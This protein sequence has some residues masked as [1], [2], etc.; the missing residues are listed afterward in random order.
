MALQVWRLLVLIV[1]IA[2]MTGLLVRSSQAGR[3]RIRAGL[4]WGAAFALAM[5]LV[6][7]PGLTFLSL[8]RDFGWP[9]WLE[10]WHQ[11]DPG[12][13]ATALVLMGIGGA[14]AWAARPALAD[15]DRRLA[16]ETA[17]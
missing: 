6:A 2:A 11:R 1:V 9:G 12:G 3:I 7:L 8:V 13:R 4:A 16:G 17:R 14:L 10:G 5:I 15:I